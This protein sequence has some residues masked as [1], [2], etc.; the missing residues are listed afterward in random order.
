MKGTTFEFKEIVMTRADNISLMILVKPYSLC[1][2]GYHEVWRWIIM[3]ILPIIS[4]KWK[5]RV[6]AGA[7]GKML[8][9]NDFW[10]CVTTSD[11]SF[12]YVLLQ[13]AMK[14]YVTGDE[15][16]E[17]IKKEKE[18]KEKMEG[19]MIKSEGGAVVELT[20]YAELDSDVKMVEMNPESAEEKNKR[21]RIRMM[22]TMTV[23]KK[24]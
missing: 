9:D 18:I 6:D 19:L 16:N 14:H 12:V 24:L 20:N 1:S 7:A 3:V 5:A 8:K 11:I 4:S 13:W 21:K 2:E 10:D 22:G 15:L 17:H 23:R